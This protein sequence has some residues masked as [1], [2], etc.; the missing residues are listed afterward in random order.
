MALINDIETVSRVNSCLDL[1]RLAKILPPGKWNR[2]IELLE[3][4]R[5]TFSG[6]PTG[7]HLKDKATGAVDDCQ[8]DF[9]LE[10][11]KGR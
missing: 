1:E 7:F 10:P 9:G 11:I 2:F 6:D 4:G 5:L 8:R 3:S